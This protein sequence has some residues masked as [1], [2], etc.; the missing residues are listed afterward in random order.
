MRILHGFWLVK[1]AIDIKGSL[2]NQIGNF[3]KWTGYSLI[4]VT[5]CSVSRYDNGTMIM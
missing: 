1:P 3:N 4:L 5:Y 2:G